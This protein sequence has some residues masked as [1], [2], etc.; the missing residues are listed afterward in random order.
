MEKARD[1]SAQILRLKWDGA[2]REFKFN[3]A[4]MRAAED[5]YDE[6]YSKK[7]CTWVAILS[8][9][10][11][12]KTAAVMAVYYGALKGAYPEL[13]FEEFDEK[14]RFTNIPEVAD[15]L[16]QAVAGALPQAAPGA[17]KNV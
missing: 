2:E 12:G 7:D 8:D 11:K 17:A 6:V 15:K 4:A 10:S 14:F 5:V 1:I 16:A 9:L 13:S 3:N